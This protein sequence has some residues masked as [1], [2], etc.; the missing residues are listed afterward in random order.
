MEKSYFTQRL[1]CEA[2]KHWL[3]YTTVPVTGMNPDLVLSSF[4]IN[5]SKSYHILHVQ[6]SELEKSYSLVFVKLDFY[7][8]ILA[9]KFEFQKPLQK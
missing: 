2:P 7:F 6:N 8:Q 3:K 5:Y 4:K 1:E 9:S